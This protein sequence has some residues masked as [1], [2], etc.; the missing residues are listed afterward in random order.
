MVGWPGWPT[1]SNPRLQE[2]IA[3]E[4]PFWYL[5]CRLVKSNLQNADCCRG[6]VGRRLLHT[7]IVPQQLLAGCACDNWLAPDSNQLTHSGE[8][9]SICTDGFMSTKQAQLKC[10]RE[11]VLKHSHRICLLYWRLRDIISK[12][13]QGEDGI[14]LPTGLHFSA[15][16][17][18]FGFYRVRVSVATA[19]CWMPSLIGNVYGTVPLRSLNVCLVTQKQNGPRNVFLLP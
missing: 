5:F 19:R 14:K 17:L 16:F 12:W 2:A 15:M 18:C 3:K 7:P 1:Q 13:H 4:Y 10:S 6:P 9:S 8:E 11:T